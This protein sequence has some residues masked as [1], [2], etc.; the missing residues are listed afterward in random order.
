VTKLCDVRLHEL[1]EHGELLPNTGVHVDVC[2][3]GGNAGLRIIM[4]PFGE[5]HDVLI[6]AFESGWR[7][8][9]H[10]HGEDPVFVVE[11]TNTKAT[12]EDAAGQVLATADYA[13]G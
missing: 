4:D 2:E 12:V 9:I 13:A 11:L 5:D 1:D 3:Q 10:P 7:L 6:E 8:L